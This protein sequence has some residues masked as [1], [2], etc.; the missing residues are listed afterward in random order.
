MKE[1][2]QITI[3]HYRLS[4]RDFLAAACLTL[5]G[6]ISLASDETRAATRW[7]LLADTHV[8]TVDN[9]ANPPRNHHYFDPLGNT[10]KIM[11][12]VAADPGAGMIIA[13]DL[14]RL[15]G[16]T[17]D[18]RNLAERLA[19]LP[20]KCPVFMALGNHDHRENFRDVFKK[21][22][23]L[24][25]PLEDRHVTVIDA[26]PVRFILL[27]T[28][29]QVNVTAGE[30]GEAQITWLKNFLADGCTTPT[31]IVLHHNVSPQGGIA[32]AAAFFDVIRPARCVKAVVF[33]HSHVHRYTAH[34]GIHLINV[35]AV[36]YSFGELIPIG[37][38]DA[39]L[40]S[41][42]G[43]FRLNAIAGPQ[44]ADPVTELAWRT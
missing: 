3:S 39:T 19:L 6:R 1:D 36:G 44:P 30:L 29:K 2:K 27:D 11:A 20:E 37:W 33:G 21:T 14:A 9:K 25:A 10:A 23:G 7:A 43:R 18:Y 34:E 22:P 15:D 12:A 28:L 5:V 31:L 41:A 26:P 16:Q 38:I 35:P 13:G 17:G 42:A 8:P 24:L 40:T 4:R 32:D